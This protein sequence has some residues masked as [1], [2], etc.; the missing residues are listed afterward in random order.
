H[1]FLHQIL[2]Q[3]FEDLSEGDAR[4]AALITAHGRMVGYLECLGIEDGILC[5]F[6]PDLIG[7][8]PDAIRRYVFATQ[9][10][11]EDVTGEID[12]V[13]V[14][15]EGWAAATQMADGIHP[16]PTRSL[17]APA[18]YLW[19]PRENAAQ[20]TAALEE[21]GYE[22]ATEDR[23]EA[24]RVANGA[25]RWGHEMH[26]G[27]LPQE[28]GIDAWAV[29]YNKGCY[30]G[31]EAMAKIHFRGKANRRLA[32]VEL[33]GPAAAGSEIE[34]A[35]ARVGKLTSAAGDKGLAIVRHDVPV[36]ADVLIEDVEA[37]VLT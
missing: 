2:T 23:L 3:S 25:P 32:R 22:R 24:L 7:T 31:Q 15:G 4:D 16:H 1:W 5:H 29:H 35:G 30:V 10:D 33:A 37:R 21:A 14:T 36:G 18:G 28:A 20:L 34:L 17:G 11:I 13:L 19:T 12:L 26:T 27:S 9:V 6:E 8:L